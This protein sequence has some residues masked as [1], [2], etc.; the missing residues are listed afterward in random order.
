MNN[1]HFSFI[2]FMLLLEAFD[3]EQNPG[4]NNFT[5]ALSILHLNMRSIRNKLDYIKDTFL[6][7]DILCFSETHLDVQS[8]NEFLFLSDT[9]AGVMIYFNSQLIHVRMADL[10]IFCDESI[11]VEIKV[12]SVSCLLGLFYSS[13]TADVNFINNL[14]LNIRKAND[15]S[16]N[17][18]I[19]GDLNEDLFNL[20]YENLKDLII[21]NS[22]KNT[23]E[24]STRQQALLDPIIVSDDMLYLNSGAIETLPSISDHKATYIRIPFNYQCQFSFKRLVWIYKNANIVQLKEISN[25]DWSILLEGSL[26][27][28]K[29]YYNFSRIC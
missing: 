18:I 13:R 5:A 15:F 17:V 26:N 11:W 9:F 7:F 4:P 1:Y 25:H 12:N 6:D 24:D 27:E 2:L 10:E 8:S 22:L 23:I 29:F 20:N 19:V 21:I 16:K 3:I 14:N 28:Y